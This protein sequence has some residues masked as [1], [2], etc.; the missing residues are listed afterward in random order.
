MIA[1]EPNPVARRRAKRLAKRDGR[2]V[3]VGRHLAARDREHGFGER[4][5]AP[6]RRASISSAGAPGR[7]VR[8]AR[9]RERATRDPSRRPQARRRSRGRIARRPERS[10]RAPARERGATRRPSG[11]GGRAGAR[12]RRELRGSDALEL[13]VVAR[14]EQRG[15]S[16]PRIVQSGRRSGRSAASHRARRRDR[17]RSRRRRSPGSRPARAAAASPAAPPRA[18]AAVPTCRRTPARIRRTRRDNGRPRAG[19]RTRPRGRGASPRARRGPL[20]VVDDRDARAAATPMDDSGLAH[21]GRRRAARAAR[22][23]FDPGRTRRAPFGLPGTASRRP[24]SPASRRRRAER[25]GGSIRLVVRRARVLDEEDA[26]A[27]VAAHERDSRPLLATG[28]R[29]ALPR[30]AGRSPATSSRDSRR[31]AGR[32][33]PGPPPRRAICSHG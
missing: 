10:S 25:N 22:R 17:C 6:A 7:I 21:R 13:H 12:G 30:R 27:H 16:R 23:R 4:A 18:P 1:A 19:A 9:W 20:H 24:R 5:R 14:G 29:P 28:S 3:P 32:S 33:T 15:R 11:S 26:V 2:S 8:R 31:G